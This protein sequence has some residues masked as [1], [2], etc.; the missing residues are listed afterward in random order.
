[1][2]C[3]FQV[4]HKG[5]PACMIQFHRT[6]YELPIKLEWKCTTALET[7]LE[8]TNNCTLTNFLCGA[9]VDFPFLPSSTTPE[10]TSV[11]D[12]PRHSLLH[13]IYPPLSPAENW[14]VNQPLKIVAL[15]RNLV[16]GQSQK[17]LFKMN[18]LFSHFGTQSRWL[19]QID[20]HGPV[21]IK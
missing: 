10:C 1:M 5:K 2:S 20:I 7:Q 4:R 6:F 18:P 13:S 11:T 19:C 16:M 9:R 15:L 3:K 14:K 12:S 21:I 17:P 8:I